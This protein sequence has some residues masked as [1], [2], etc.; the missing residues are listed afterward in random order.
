MGRIGRNGQIWK[1]TNPPGRFTPPRYALRRVKATPRCK[2]VGLQSD[3]TRSKRFTF[4][5][6]KFQNF[7]ART[8]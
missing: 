1:T 8:N 2:A 3:T 7:I 5:L 6:Q 4:L